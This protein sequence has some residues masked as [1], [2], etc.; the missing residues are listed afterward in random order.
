MAN[1]I[2]NECKGKGVVFFQNVDGEFDCEPCL[3]TT[4]KEMTTEENCM[5]CGDTGIICMDKSYDEFGDVDWEEPVFCDCNQ[6]K[7]EVVE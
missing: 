2:C 7:M 4:Y 6:Y 5:I 3:C 1:K